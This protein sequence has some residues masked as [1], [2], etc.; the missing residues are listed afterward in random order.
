VGSRSDGGKEFHSL[1][2][3]AAKLRGPKLDVRQASTCK[4]PRA[5]E[6]RWWRLVLAVTGNAQL[7]EVLQSSLMATLEDDCS[8]VIYTRSW[9]GHCYFYAGAGCFIKHALDQDK[10]Q[11]IRCSIVI[12]SDL[13]SWHYFLT[14]LCGRTFDLRLNSRGF[15]SRPRHAIGHQP[16]ASCSH[17]LA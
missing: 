7:L 11:I 15:I 17:P 4:S 3:Q 5:A 16:Y 14:K 6:H 9:R 8:C 10:Y 12:S 2:A 1:G 13:S